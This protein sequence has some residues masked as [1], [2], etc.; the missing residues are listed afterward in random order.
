MVLAHS[1][2]EASLRFQLALAR[3]ETYVE[4]RPSEGNG[5]RHDRDNR[6]RISKALST[7]PPGVD[8]TTLG[9]HQL[10]RRV[11]SRPAKPRDNLS[12]CRAADCQSEGSDL[13][14]SSRGL[15]NPWPL[16]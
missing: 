9:R 12:Y 1:V 5:V 2:A 8:S 4:Q 3:N 11:K 13:I 16:T 14:H 15:L 6:V 10:P 7:S